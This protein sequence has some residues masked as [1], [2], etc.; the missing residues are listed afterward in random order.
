MIYS[1]SDIQQN[2][3]KLVILG[4]FLPFYPNKNPKNQKFEKWK[5]LLE[6]SSFYKCGPKIIIPEIQTN[7]VIL[8]HFL[9][10]YLPPLMIPNI[11][12]LKKKKKM[13]WDI[14]RLYVHVYHKWRSYDIWFLKYKMQQTKFFDILGHF[15][16]FYLPS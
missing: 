5:N 9:L 1:S 14:T 16:P 6:I 2:I 11:K 8:G 4:H 12:I 15:L 13:A 3:M 7:F 10:F